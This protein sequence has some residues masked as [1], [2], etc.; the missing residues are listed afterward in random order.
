MSCLYFLEIN[1][2]TVT[3]FANI[4]SCFIVCLFNFVDGFL[5]CEKTFSLIRSCLFISLFIF[6]TLGGG[7]KKILLRSVSKSVLPMFSSRIFT[8][9]SLTF[10]FIF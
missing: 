1:S 8:I 7:S 9:S 3:S 2:L 4:F 10:I 5:C 6:I